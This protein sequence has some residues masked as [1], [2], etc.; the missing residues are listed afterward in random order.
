MGIYDRD[1]YDKITKTNKTLGSCNIL[2]ECIK[3]I[4]MTGVFIIMIFTTELFLAWIFMTGVFIIMI[5][6]T[7]VFLARI[8]MTGVFMT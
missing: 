2:T 4:F 7:E 3:G 8:F 1:F 5:F 6:T